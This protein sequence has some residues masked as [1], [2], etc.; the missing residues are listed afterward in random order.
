MVGKIVIVEPDRAGTTSSHIDDL[1][2]QS[3]YRYLWL[4]SKAKGYNFKERLKA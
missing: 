4:L 2:V 1:L 3:I